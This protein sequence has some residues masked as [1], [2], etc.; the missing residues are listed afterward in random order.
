MSIDSNDLQGLAGAAVIGADGDKIGDVGQFYLS[1]I[2]GE[3]TWATVKTGLF[4]AQESF[5]PLQGSSVSRGQLHVA[6]DKARVKDAP[7]MDTDGHLTPQ[8]ED[9]LYR[10]YGIAD[11]EAVDRRGTERSDGPA[12]RDADLAGHAGPEGLSDTRAS[13]GD[14]T[15]TGIV[16]ASPRRN[17]DDPDDTGDHHDDVDRSD[18]GEASRRDDAGLTRDISADRD[19][20]DAVTPG[21]TRT[22]MRRYIVTEHVTQTVEELP[23]NNDGH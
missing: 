22:R 10:F 7:R 6:F 3:P 12:R 14:D 1:D 16:G 2:S 8:E 23:D 5:V 15:T 18:D 19:D 21:E 17:D 20:L 11:D 4:G 9:T 13:A